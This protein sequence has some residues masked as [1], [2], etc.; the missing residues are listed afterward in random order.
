MLSFLFELSVNLFEAFRLTSSCTRMITY[1]SVCVNWSYKGRHPSSDCLHQSHCLI[2]CFPS[3]LWQ[4]ILLS[5]SFSAF[6]SC[7]LTNSCFCLI[8]DAFGYFRCLILICKGGLKGLELPKRKS[9]N[10]KKPE[11]VGMKDKRSLM[12]KW[13]VQ[14]INRGRREREGHRQES[15]T[16]QTQSCKREW[17]S[18]DSSRKLWAA[19]QAPV[20]HAVRAGRRQAWRICMIDVWTHGATASAAGLNEMCPATR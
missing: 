10:Q 19:G 11:E 4:N 2:K 16:Q 6:S 14:W 7:V 1:T 5:T 18:V 3:L 20:S 17:L 13:S 9:N 12:V 8:C 15:L